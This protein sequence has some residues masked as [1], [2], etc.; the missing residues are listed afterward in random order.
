[1]FTNSLLQ[2]LF[3]TLSL[4]VACAENVAPWDPKSQLKEEH[5]SASSLRSDG[6]DAPKR[7]E[8]AV[9]ILSWFLVSVGVTVFVIFFWT[10]KVQI[11]E[12]IVKCWTTTRADTSS[13]NQASTLNDIIFDPEEEQQASLS[14]SLLRSNSED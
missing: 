5:M 1:M 10:L 14:Q 2:F 9:I 4:T 13:G 11:K 7:S 6:T 8:R 3:L 12:F